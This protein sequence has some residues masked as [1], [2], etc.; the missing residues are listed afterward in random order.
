ML[1]KASSID[2]GCFNVGYT[3]LNKDELIRP[4]RTAPGHAARR[5]IFLLPPERIGTCPIAHSLARLE[6]IDQATI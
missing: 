1:L 4:G 2:E 5:V 6:E 3:V